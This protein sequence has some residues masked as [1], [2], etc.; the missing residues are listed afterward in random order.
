M[1]HKIF[2]VYDSC[3]ESY[4]PPFF[5]PTKGQAVRAFSDCAKDPRHMF[6]KHPEHYVLFE[7]GHFDDSNALIELHRAPVS[8]GRAIEYAPPIADLSSV[9]T[10]FAD[11]D[12]QA[13][14]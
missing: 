12:S 3:A 7:I 1:L 14:S 4:L 6:G 13:V 8:L 9:P 5:L 11:N 2:S 10:M